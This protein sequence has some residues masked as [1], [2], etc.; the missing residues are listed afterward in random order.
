MRPFSLVLA[1]AAA[2]TTV[3]ALAW[4]GEYE[5]VIDE[6]V[7]NITGKPLKKITVNGTIP[8]PALR[9]K[10][11]EQ[12]VVRV[13]NRLKENTSVH[14]H[15]LILPPEQDGVPGF[16][17][18]PGIKPGETYTYRFP[19]QQSGTY[20]YH[21]HSATQEQS[22]H[23]G[24]L[25]IEPAAAP[26]VQ[27][28]REYTVLLS[29]FTEEDPEEIIENLKVDPGFYNYEKRTLPDFFRDARK[30]GFRAAWRD[31]KAWGRMRMDPTDIAD[32][33]NYHFLVNGKPAAK[34]ETFLFRPGERVKLRFI[35]AAAMTYF[36]VR[37]PG[38]KM[39]VV[40]ADGRPVEPVAVDEFRFAVSETYDVIVEPKTEQAF[41]VFAES[42]DR[43]GYARATLAPHE[44]MAAPVPAMRPRALLT[45]AEMGH[46]M[47][48]MDGHAGMGH[49]SG[50]A[51][52]G[53]DHAAMG[54]GAPSG[55]AQP[56]D[57]AATGHGPAPA[58]GTD[59]AAMD[60]S[61]MGHGS[62]PAQSAQE[63]GSGADHSTVD[64]SGMGHGPAPAQ[65]TQ[66]TT[67]DHAPMDHSAMGHGSA[68]AGMHQPVRKQAA[69]R[70]ALPQVDYGMGKAVDMAGMD[71]G[72]TGGDG[73]MDMFALAPEGEF[74][75][76]GRVFGWASGA[77]HGSKVLSYAD[78]RS[79]AP[80]QDLR[81]AERELI[82]RL[83]G[84]MERYIWTLNG[85]KFGEAE[86][87]QLRYGE[88][89]KLTF[90]NE[91]M[92]AH[93]MHLHGMF[94]QLDNG[95][96][97]ERLPDK[98]V[99]SVA[100]GKTYSVLITADQAGEWAFH[101]HLLYHMESGMMQKVV[102]ARLDGTAASGTAPAQPDPHAGHG[103]GS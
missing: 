85:A 91:T 14:W 98:N 80:Q 67:T 3:P 78:L 62:T 42:I 48:R 51:A 35:N 71:H 45:M 49:G 44:G 20:W 57:H 34:N 93:P 87:F 74:D 58:S 76:S 10:E 96:P 7:V 79:E 89:V 28:D 88:R 72:S 97:A 27:A 92:M 6:Q 65:T 36:D 38:L 26:A 4:A 21:A 86:P 81:P 100:P 23:Y 40:A 52:A 64:H 46:N 11:G 32:V 18:F 102:V 53:V 41:T 17:G 63:G 29:D 54:H 50:P 70:T 30:F 16:N 24:P 95:Q 31:R 61:A 39:T 68:H 33:A 5:L 59:H 75:G 2:L 15:G 22:G 66:P 8:G 13:T 43:T 90:V 12:V 73:G 60:H 37:I 94:M 19:I 83:S 84:N 101:C 77:P 56:M 25:I 82:V 9:F 99:V 55:A 1:A 69:G 103:G 47:S